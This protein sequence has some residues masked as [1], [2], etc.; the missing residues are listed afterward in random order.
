MQRTLLF[1]VLH[2]SS[3]SLDDNEIN[4]GTNLIAFRIVNITCGILTDI[5]L[6][7]RIHTD[8]VDII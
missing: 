2:G 5:S 4:P 6:K 3:L 1:E 7:N 8:L